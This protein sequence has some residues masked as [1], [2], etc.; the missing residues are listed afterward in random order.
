VKFKIL[1]LVT[2]STFLSSAWAQ[3]ASLM[4]DLNQR[5]SQ[6]EDDLRESKDVVETLRHEI[7]KLNTQLADLKNASPAPM[8][9]NSEATPAKMLDA[10]PSDTPTPTPSLS[11]K[12]AYEQAR[13]LLEK[14]DYEAAE[15]AFANF[16]QQYPKDE[17][18]ANGQY[19]WGV[20]FFVR[21]QH[22][23]AVP[24]FAKGFKQYP[25]APK[26]PDMLMK[27]A[28]SLGK[29]NR[30]ADACT[31]LKQLGTAYPDAYKAERDD[32]MKTLACP[33]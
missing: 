33:K 6:M 19:W 9:G 4:A 15:K 12:D 13:A 16:V 32:E 8:P 18:A 24:I 1:C 27:M 29:L 5:V 23:K 22:E 21:G 7:Q 11:A 30:T 20:T 2:V 10:A 26:A 28:K 17:N 14:A 3:D 25:K 31:T